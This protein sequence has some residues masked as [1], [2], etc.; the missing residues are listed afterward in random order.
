M[1]EVAVYGIGALA[2]LTAL[3]VQGLVSVRSAKRGDSTLLVWIKSGCAGGFAMI[4]GVALL[5]VIANVIS[6]LGA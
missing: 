4:G 1:E 2:L 3:I 6:W 5:F